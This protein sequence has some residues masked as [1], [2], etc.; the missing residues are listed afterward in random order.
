MCTI[1]RAV[2][3]LPASSQKGSWNHCNATVVQ[4]DACRI[5]S[6]EEFRYF[7][8]TQENA[9]ALHVESE[10]PNVS[11]AYV[12]RCAFDRMVA[13]PWG[14]PLQ[15]CG[16]RVTVMT[17]VLFFLLLIE[18]VRVGPSTFR[19][20]K[21]QDVESV[22]LLQDGLRSQ[23]SYPSPS[24][25]RKLRCSL[26]PND[27]YFSKIPRL[28]GMRTSCSWSLYEFNFCWLSQGKF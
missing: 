14:S 18:Q 24:A 26:H 4:K 5:G 6:E 2:G 17:V 7:R 13:T 11:V 19:S 15:K 22:N 3:F 16:P 1:K 20:A 10:S 8:P 21:C 23:Y 12:L 28:I 9:E 27:N 25:Y